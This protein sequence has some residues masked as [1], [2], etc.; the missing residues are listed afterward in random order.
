MESDD[1]IPAWLLVATSWPAV[2]GVI[3]LPGLLMATNF[4]FGRCG[5]AAAIEGDDL[6]RGRRDTL[7]RLTVLATHAS[8]WWQLHCVQCVLLEPCSRGV[9]LPLAHCMLTSA[10]ICLHTFAAIAKPASTRAGDAEV[11]FCRR[12]QRDVP[13][14]DHHCPF[15]HTCVGGHNRVAYVALL[16]V[17]AALAAIDV[18]CFGASALEEHLMPLMQTSFISAPGAQ[19]VAPALWEASAVATA[20]HVKVAVG[21]VVAPIAFCGAVWLLGI[22]AF[23]VAAGHGTTLAWLKSRRKAATEADTEG[24]GAP[25]AERANVTTQRFALSVAYKGE[26]FHGNQAQSGVLTVHSALCDAVA[27]LAPSRRRGG[28]E[29]PQVVFAGRTDSGVHA[30]GM[31]AHC[32]LPA[33]ANGKSLAPEVVQRAIRVALRREGHATALDVTAVAA[34]PASFHARVSCARR[35]YRYRLL[36]PANAT[37][38]LSD[39]PAA[40]GDV[41]FQR[42]LAWVVGDDS[43]PLTRCDVAAL[44]DVFARFVGSHDFNAFRDAR[45]HATCSR[46]RVDECSL[47]VSAGAPDGWQLVEVSIVAASFMKHQV[48]AMV[49]AAVAVATGKLPAGSVDQ[50]LR[51]AKRA[52]AMRHAAPPWGLYFI[53]ADYP[54]AAYQP[55]AAGTIFRP[56]GTADGEDA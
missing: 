19:S 25:V 49:G 33:A 47:V 20:A 8:I 37:A 40:P 21:L 18:V 28:A 3:A 50:W 43:G 9:W 39:A 38:G 46:R 4:I 41:F 52:T 14:R 23:V 55:C 29:P 48:R 5:V 42:R 13:G 34:V 51:D 6:P 11:S 36:I 44:R 15:L 30:T 27:T 24:G 35:S 2:Y 7:G 56:A 53:A 22:Q 54:A 31:R 17:T 16:V 12:C 10:A 32:D 45:C 1:E 26:A